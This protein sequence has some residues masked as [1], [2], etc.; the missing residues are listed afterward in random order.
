VLSC[1]GSQP[2]TGLDYKS[3]NKV[4]NFIKEYYENETPTII[5]ADQEDSILKNII[6]GRIDLF[7]GRLRQTDE[8]YQKIKKLDISML[9]IRPEIINK[10]EDIKL[11]LKKRRYKILK[12][13]KLTNFSDKVSE[14]YSFDYPD[15]KIQDIFQK[16]YKKSDFGDLFGVLV[17]NHEDGDTI[18]KLNSEIGHFKAYQDTKNN[19]L[20]SLFGLPKENNYVEK[21]FTLVFCGLHR[22]N[23]VD[24]FIIHLNLSGIKEFDI[25]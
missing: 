12:S 6:S 10:F 5:F 4:L 21:S 16:A 2:F 18:K 20:R 3:I 24:D 1:F 11:E 19:S 7:S 8:F 9:V 25:K 13:Y 14:M 15:K 17:I 23:S 22:T